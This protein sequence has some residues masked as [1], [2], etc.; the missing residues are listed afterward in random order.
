MKISFHLHVNEN[1]FSNERVSTRTRFKKEAKGSSEMAYS[2]LDIFFI[3]L[4]TA[5][6]NGA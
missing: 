4:S 3:S 2:F 1:Y 5:I 6:E